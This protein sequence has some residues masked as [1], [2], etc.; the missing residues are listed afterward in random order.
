MT[1][2]LTYLLNDAC[3]K[4]LIT[5][6]CFKREFKVCHLIYVN[7]ILLCF[8]ANERSCESNRHIFHVYESLTNQKINVFK[9]EIFFP[10]KTIR[11]VRRE[12]CNMLYREGQ[13]PLKYLRALIAPKRV[14]KSDL[15]CV[16]QSIIDKIG[17]W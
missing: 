7:G 14:S 16:V 2:I 9:S 15:N 17:S 11:G 12:I 13:F 4:K 6:F 3:D 1:Q 10:R 5:L 8:W